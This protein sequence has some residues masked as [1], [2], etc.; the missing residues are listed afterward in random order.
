MRG[1]KSSFKSSRAP[2]SHIVWLYIVFIDSRVLTLSRTHDTLTLHRV[3]RPQTEGGPRGGRG[4]G[5]RA[6]SVTVSL[7]EDG[8]A[9][10]GED[11]VTR[12]LFRTL[13]N[14]YIFTVL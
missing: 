4:R 10:T 8:D 11:S 2:F 9:D 12:D 3:Q 5:S 6:L 7:A 1:S 13:L 14:L